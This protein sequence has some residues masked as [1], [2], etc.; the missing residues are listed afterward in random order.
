MIFSIGELM[1]F[2]EVRTGVPTSVEVRVVRETV[3]MEPDG[4]MTVMV[5]RSRLQ[6]S[7]AL[8]CLM[9]SF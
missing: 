7:R 6:R 1:P 3:N 5:A 9:V 4:S 8:M 2:S